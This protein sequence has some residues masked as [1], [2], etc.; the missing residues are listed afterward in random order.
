MKGVGKGV[1]GLI[2]KPVVGVVDLIT[3]TT[4]GIKNSAV[5][6]DEKK[7][8]I[9]PPRYIG[10]D[11]ILLIYDYDKSW[12]QFL[13]RTIDNAVYD[14]QFL[15]D[16]IH[17]VDEKYL[18][19]SDKMILVLVVKPK[20]IVRKARFSFSGYFPFFFTIFLLFYFIFYFFIFLFFLFY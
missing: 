4:E 12:G 10:S 3:D 1:T 17:L 16:F 11:L 8:R 6:F 7:N 18:I 15:V 2:L 19:I 9:R 14:N 5:Y 20:N 13:L